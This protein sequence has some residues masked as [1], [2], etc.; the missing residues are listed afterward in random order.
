MSDGLFQIDPFDRPHVSSRGSQGQT[1]PAS[2]PDDLQKANNPE[3]SASQAAGEIP[4]PASD[5]V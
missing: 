1:S 4:I 5:D 3:D 2:P